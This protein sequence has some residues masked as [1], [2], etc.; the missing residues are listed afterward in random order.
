MR[1]IEIADVLEKEETFVPEGLCL[2]A[3]RGAG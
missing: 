1:R 2:C 3:R